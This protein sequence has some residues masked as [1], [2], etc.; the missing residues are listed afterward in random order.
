MCVLASL[1]C[2]C[3]SVTPVCVL[4]SLL[5]V[6]VSITPVCM[7]VCVSHIT[8]SFTVCICAL[9]CRHSYC[10]DQLFT[11]P[12][13]ESF[14]GFNLCTHCDPGSHY[15]ESHYIRGSHDVFTLQHMPTIPT[16]PP[17]HTHICKGDLS[18]QA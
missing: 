17:T 6:C 15:A 14:F 18:S 7:C 2:V 1:L 16:P 12:P 5:S 10:G 3:V 11:K 13:V 8:T 9:S 4:A